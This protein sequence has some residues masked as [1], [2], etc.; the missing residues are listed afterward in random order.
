MYCILLSNICQHI[1]PVL[2]NNADLPIYRSGFTFHCFKLPNT[3]END[4]Q[5]NESGDLLAGLSC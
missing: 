2:V 4:P 5:N 3:T 1:D